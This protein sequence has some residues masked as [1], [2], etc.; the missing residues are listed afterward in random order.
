[1]AFLPAR[2]QKQL[3]CIL[4]LVLS[5]TGIYFNSLKGS[6]QFDDVP[7]ISNQWIED[8][9]SFN[10][11]VKI[12]SFENRPVLLWTYALNN[13]LGK[14]KE[15]GFHL[16]NL[17]LHIGVTLLIFFSVLKTSYFQESFNDT[18]N[19][20]PGIRNPTRIWIFP[21][22]TALIFSLHPL[23]TDSISYISSRSSVLA[24]FFY[25][26]S[27]YLFLNLFS[28]E[29]KKT[30]LVNN[31]F[32]IP[33]VVATMYLSLASKLIAATLPLLMSFWYFVFI[34]SRKNM[35]ALWKR[36]WAYLLLLLI[37][38]AA[39]FLSGGS[40]LY[41]AKDQGLEL[42]G[43][44]PYLLIQIKVIVFYYLRLFLFPFNLSVDSGMPFSSINEDPFII[45]AIVIISGIVAAAIK[46]RNIW[47]LAGTAWFFI[48]LAPTSSFMPLN[49]LAVEHRTYLPMTLGICMAVGWGISRLCSL[50]RV[51]FL[52][53]IIIALSLTTITRNSDWISEISL[54]EDV[55]RKNPSSSRAHN[56]LGKAYFEKGD[57]TRASYHFEKSIAN[58]PKFIEDKFNLKN[59]EEFLSRKRGAA[60]SNNPNLRIAAELVEPHYNLASIYLDQGKLG[61]AEKEYL[62]TLSLRP[63]HSSAKIGLGSVYN[64][65]GLYEKAEKLY[66][67]AIKDKQSQSG[68]DFFPLAHLNLGEVYGKTGKISLAIAEWEQAI[69]QG[70]SLLPAHFNLG[71]ALMMQGEYERAEKY[72][73]KCLELNNKHEPALFNLA[74]VKQKQMHWQDSI[75]RF[76]NYMAVTGPKPSSLTQI[77]FNYLNLKDW[78]NAQSFFEKSLSILPTDMNT[79]ILLGDAFLAQGHARKAEEKYRIALNLSKDSGLEKILKNK[80]K[81]I[82]K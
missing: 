62:K 13:S 43:Q 76:N 32:L 23:N 72:L 42:Y 11:F 25:L 27:L 30:P 35:E 21:F 18:R 69:Q 16:L 50:W 10:Q 6:F 5:S 67:Q 51:G 37:S 7:L 19:K 48:T 49:D 12:S 41:N 82:S 73:L 24:T 46:S 78:T 20:N 59:A 66:R 56:N 53:L 74:L 29:K 71:T 38:I 36:N 58:I 22:I 17:M 79:L 8:L 4:L 2:I 14:N 65:K 70:P 28:P 40:W 63:D 1:M 9:D 52:S 33:L 55:A 68:S 75:D 3:A 57:L 39:L 34:F 31:L 77:G 45:F 80:I 54:W 15:F 81:N 47:L 44:L 60:N 64:K 61:L 26:L